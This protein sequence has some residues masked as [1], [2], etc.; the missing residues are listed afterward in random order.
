MHKKNNTNIK[1]NLAL[2]NGKDLFQ[3][4]DNNP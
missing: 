4:R 2:P 1:D 3:K